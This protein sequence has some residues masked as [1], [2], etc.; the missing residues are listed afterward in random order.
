VGDGGYCLLTHYF[1]VFTP[2]LCGSGVSVMGGGG[3]FEGARDDKACILMTVC[4]HVAALLLSGLHA[5]LRSL[6]QSRKTSLH[7]AVYL[8][9]SIVF[10]A[11]TI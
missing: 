10:I 9:S 4:R 2:F 3:G 1:L 6:T 5:C 7:N 11:P 8:Q